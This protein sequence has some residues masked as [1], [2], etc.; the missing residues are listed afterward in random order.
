M[1]SYKQV[2]LQLHSGLATGQKVRVEDVKSRKSGG[3]LNGPDL[4]KQYLSCRDQSLASLDALACFSDICAAAQSQDQLQLTRESAEDGQ[5]RAENMVGFAGT[6]SKCTDAG[7]NV[8]AHF[9]QQRNVFAVVGGGDSLTAQM[10][11]VCSPI[12]CCVPLG[13]S[14]A[15]LAQ[16]A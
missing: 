7:E 2:T 1:T 3:S 6:N 5:E 8:D 14:G 4:F 15:S 9:F 16:S 13:P 11:A 10:R 12:L